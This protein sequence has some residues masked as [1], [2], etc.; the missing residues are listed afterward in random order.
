MLTSKEVRQ[1]TNPSAFGMN[2]SSG[3]DGTEEY[4]GAKED[5]LYEEGEEEENNHVDNK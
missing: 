4:G 3:S 2:F 5:I 1:L